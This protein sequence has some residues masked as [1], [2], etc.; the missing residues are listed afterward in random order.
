MDESPWG[1]L[2]GKPLD[3]RGLSRR[4]SAYDVKPK[5]L[6]IDGKIPKGYDAADLADPWSRYLTDA[7]SASPQGSATSA[8]SATEPDA[9][10]PEVTLCEVTP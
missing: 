9:L 10:W 6:R 5:N 3:A 4:L 2:R 1:D 7:S 8:T